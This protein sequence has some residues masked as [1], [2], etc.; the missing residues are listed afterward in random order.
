M[1]VSRPGHVSGGT[2]S[3]PRERLWWGITSGACALV[4][5]VGFAALELLPFQGE[6][7]QNLLL[8]FVMDADDWKL[9]LFVLGGLC[10]SVTLPCLV[11]PPVNKIRFTWLRRGL[12]TLLCLLLVMA[13]AC[14]SLF[15]LLLLL[16]ASRWSYS[17]YSDTE[18]HRVLVRW[19][20]Y[21]VEI[22]TPYAGPL[23]EEYRD[24][25]LTD[26]GAV[27]AET[28]SLSAGDPGLVLTCGRDRITM[29]EAIR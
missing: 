19:D 18:G 15:S 28:C 11:P 13:L 24:G 9:I 17:T 20:S 25:S 29:P 27:T 10:L 2:E 7:E 21:S 8:Y 5:F 22:W 14:W 12:K 1:A 26:M 4:L 16:I 6:T 23:Y 3:R